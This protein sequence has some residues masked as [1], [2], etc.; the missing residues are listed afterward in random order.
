M[1][2]KLNTF[3]ITKCLIRSIAHSLEKF[4]A[5]YPN[6][7]RITSVIHNIYYVGVQNDITNPV[8][9]LGTDIG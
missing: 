7:N 2:L 9:L 1:D 5:M 8:F 4:Q 3:Q 6:K